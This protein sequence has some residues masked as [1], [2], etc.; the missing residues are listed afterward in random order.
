MAHTIRITD[1]AAMDTVNLNSGA[2]TSTRF[3]PQSPAPQTGN[4]AISGD[5]GLLP[6]ERADVT[7]SIELFI[8]ETTI[9]AVQSARASLGRLEERARLRQFTGTGPRVFLEVQYD[10]E[11]IMWRSEIL[12]MRTTFPHAGEQISRLKL[13]AVLTLTRRY[14]FET[15]SEVALNMTS[16]E[17]TVAA[18]TAVVYNN[19]DAVAATTNWFSIAAAQLPGNLPAPLRLRLTNADAAAQ[20]WREFYITNYVHSTPGSIDP[21]RR[22]SETIDGAT[23]AWATN[24]EETAWAWDLSDTTLGHLAGKEYRILIALF[25]SSADVMYRP[26][27]RYSSI[28]IPITAATQIK[29]ASGDLYDIGAVKFPG[30]LGSL[31]TDISL[32]INVQKPGGGSVDMDFVQISPAGRGLFRRIEQLGFQ[33]ANGWGIEDNGPE[34]SVYAT[35]GTRRYPYVTGYDQPIHVWPNQQNLL[36]VLFRESDFTPGRKLNVKAWVRPRRMDI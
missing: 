33:V 24:T 11:A 34:G 7:E 25:S 19:D 20:S 27:L 17:T 1:E 28:Q 26:V 5:Y 29:G 22:G 12:I 21:I 6:F 16:G 23:F 9:A 35:D 36:R 8:Q 2:I 30:D 13:D 31:G 4:A 32:A 18:S 15:S 3:A 14:F 10:G